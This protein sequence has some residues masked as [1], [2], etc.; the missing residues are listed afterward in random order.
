[1]ASVSTQIRS[2]AAGTSPSGFS[3]ENEP[4]PST[5]SMTY[6]LLIAPA[7]RPGSDGMPID[8][9]VVLAICREA[10]L[11]L[12]AQDACRH[13]NPAATELLGYT[14]DELLA[15]QLQD[16]IAEPIDWMQAVYDQI[17]L[18]HAWRGEAHLRRKDGALVV[19]DLWS[20]RL[21][22]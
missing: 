20:I 6:T 14:R 9:A 13:A 10:I 18:D 7:R 17:L 8:V 12:D 21:E 19:A 3:H 2:G 5:S 16:L 4:P 15:I 11:V 1:G 22:D